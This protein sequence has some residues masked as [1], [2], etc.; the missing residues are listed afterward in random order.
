MDHLPTTKATASSPR[1]S[2][3]QEEERE[4]PWFPSRAYYAVKSAR[5]LAKNH[6]KIIPPPD[7]EGR[8]LLRQRLEAQLRQEQG[9]HWHVYLVPGRFG[10]YARAERLTDRGQRRGRSRPQGRR[11]VGCVPVRPNLAPRAR[12]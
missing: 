4:E 9:G 7:K 11:E 2:P 10:W 3:P 12:Q 6:M 1:P 8:E 5:N